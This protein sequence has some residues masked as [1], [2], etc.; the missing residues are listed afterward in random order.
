MS[1]PERDFLDDE[2]NEAVEQEEAVE[3][4][5]EPTPEPEKVEPKPENPAPEVPTTSETK[6]NHVP[7]AALKAEREKRQQLERELAEL[8]KKPEEPQASFYDA[9]DEYVQKAMQTAEQRATQRMYAALEAQARETYS[10]YDEV[11]EEVQ[12][13][14]QTNPAV[15][16]QILSAP[17][18]AVA[19][20][21]FGKQLR[22]FKQMQDPVAYRERIKAEIRA[23]LEA[24][25]KSREDERQKRAAA[26]PPDLT[27][28][29]SAKGNEPPPPE[30]VFS[31]IF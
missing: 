31:E 27:D 28:T 13:Y 8:R 12:A 29:R 22:E 21:K 15:V 24:E 7:L 19:A 6:E 23:E 11:T 1:D 3:S 16:N 10:D 25:A 14:A 17:N 18:P 26:I 20:Y 4:A 2:A 30:S 5:P 9:P